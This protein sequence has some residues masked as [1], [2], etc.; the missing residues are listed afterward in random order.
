[1]TSSFSRGVVQISAL[2][3]LFISGVSARAQSAPCTLNT[4]SPSVTICTPA[5][6]ATVPSP[7]NIVAGTTDNASTVSFLQIYI[8]S[9]KQYQVSGNQLNTSLPLSA[10]AHRV[11]VQAQDAAGTVFKS[12][13]NITVGS[14]SGGGPCPL[15]L[16]THRSQSARLRITQP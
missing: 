11:T 13:I 3:C 4:A 15:A 2:F 10:G 1:M 6:G 12:T 9:V 5:N 16:P 7:V 14:G 8:D